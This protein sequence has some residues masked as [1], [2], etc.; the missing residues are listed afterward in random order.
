VLWAEHG[1][2]GWERRMARVA[3]LMARRLAAC[4]MGACVLWGD[5]AGAEPFSKFDREFVLC[6]SPERAEFEASDWACQ[7]EPD[8]AAVWACQAVASEIHAKARAT[9]ALAAELA[10]QRDLYARMPR[11]LDRTGILAGRPDG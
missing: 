5:V 6:F 9:C 1:C 7:A 10:A 3:R 8:R 11:L 4:L 2:A